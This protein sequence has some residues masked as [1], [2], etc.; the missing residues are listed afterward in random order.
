MLRPIVVNLETDVSV[1][2]LDDLVRELDDLVR[3][4]DDLVRE[5]VVLVITAPLDVFLDRSDVLEWGWIEM[6]S[7]HIP[8]SDPDETM[9]PG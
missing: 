7:C 3:E 2:D 5:L 6:K 4:L 8:V 9:T 1:R